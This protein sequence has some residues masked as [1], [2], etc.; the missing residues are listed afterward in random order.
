MAQETELSW[1]RQRTSAELQALISRRLG[2]IAVESE[3]A[4]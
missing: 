1:E 4:D 2:L 3:D